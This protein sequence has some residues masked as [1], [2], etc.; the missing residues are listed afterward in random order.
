MCLPYAACW[1]LCMYYLRVIDCPARYPLK[2]F[3]LAASL[4]EVACDRR[5]ATARELLEPGDGLE[6][7]TLKFKRYFQDELS[8]SAARG[9]CPPRLWP[10]RL[11]MRRVW[12][13]D[14]RESE[15]V[16]KMIGIQG[17]RS[18]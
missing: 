10:C 7:T 9:T 17:T 3:V 18:P 2:L 14:V 8:V 6:E 16:N 11:A 4:P 5:L 12:K 13:A 15:R 1:H